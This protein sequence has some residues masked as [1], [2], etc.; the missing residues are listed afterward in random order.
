MTE[1]QKYVFDLQGYIVLKNMVPQSVVEACNKVL[2]CF[3]NMPPEE[4]PPPLV[5]GT[6][7]TEKELY[8]SNILESDPAFAPM[9]DI[10]EVL[11]IIE[12]VTGGPYRLNHTYTIYRWG[13]GY[14][15]RHGYATP[16]RPKIQYH[17]RNGQIL[18]TLTKAVFPML[19]CDVEDGCFAVIP[20]AHKSNFP[21][22][23][24]NHPNENPTLIPIPAQAGDAIIFTEALTHGSVVNVSGRPRRTVYYCYSTGYM[25]DWGGQG[26]RFSD[27]VMEN[28]TEA[29]REIIRLKMERAG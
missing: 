25:P 12:G 28:L 9:I 11:S 27:H 22:P 17:C 16:M 10:P 2:D 1:E 8:I 29:Q 21:R 4:F 3:E 13:G 18:S 6:P 15:G 20:G 14:T 19:D 7:K 5:L 24:G 23:W 26:L